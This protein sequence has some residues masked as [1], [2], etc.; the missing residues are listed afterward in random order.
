MD[1][2]RILAARET[3]TNVQARIRAF[4]DKLT[5]QEIGRFTKGNQ[6]PSTWGEAITIRINSQSGKFG[7][8]NP[9]GANFLLRVK[10][11]LNQ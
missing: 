2:T 1:N 8:N 7:V 6:V 11:A 4:D 10:G 3:S 9:Y 5:A